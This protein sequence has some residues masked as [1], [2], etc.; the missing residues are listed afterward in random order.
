MPPFGSCFTV[1]K[2]YSLAEIDVK[3]GVRRVMQLL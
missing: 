2:C 1:S 3:K